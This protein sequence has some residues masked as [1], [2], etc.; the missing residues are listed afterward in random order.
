MRKVLVGMIGSGF[1]AELHLSAYPLV[2]GIE[3]EVRAVSSLSENLEEFAS[4]FGIRD[5]YREY[6]EMLR[7]PEIEVVDIIV[8][9]ALHA[10]CIRDALAAGKHVICEKPLTGFFEGNSDPNMLQS[11]CGEIESL[12]EIVKM[13]G[14]QFM[15]AENWIYT[16]SV[17]KS[18]EILKERRGKQLFLKAEESHSGSHAGHAAY[19]KMNGGG[20]LIRQGCHPISAVLYLKSV[21][22]EIRGE[23]IKL[24]S[25]T[26]DVG[27]VSEMLG[28]SE[29]KF[30]ESRPVDVEDWA[31]AVY[32]FTDGTKACVLSGD[33]VLGGVKNYVECYGNNFVLLNNISP[34][35]AMQ[36][37]FTDEQGLENV[38]LTEKTQLKSG[39]QS[40]FLEETIARGYAGELQ[41]FMECAVYGRNPISG[42]ELACETVKAIYGAY[43]S[44]QEGK[45]IYF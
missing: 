3:V 35:T 28:E 19:W 27:N 16:P 5:T 14:K 17:Q 1:A 26:C 29:K 24:K 42:I 31:C 32:T 20:S 18:V 13:S 44:A 2:H 12:K 33:M 8:P 23:T 7:D 21:E 6:Q 39:W 43:Q 25:V 37:F 41:D 30:I 36:T 34:N 38:Y 10:Q 40:V 22:A 4:K 15:Y 11:V 45:T 9:P